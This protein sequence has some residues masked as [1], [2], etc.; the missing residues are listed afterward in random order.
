MAILIQTNSL[1]GLIYCVIHRYL[2]KDHVKKEGRTARILDSASHSFNCIN[3]AFS[4]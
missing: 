3:M 1:S 4:A 2:G